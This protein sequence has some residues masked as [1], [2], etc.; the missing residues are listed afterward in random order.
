[1]VAKLS[2]KGVATQ[3]QRIGSAPKADGTAQQKQ[4]GMKQ[5]V[6]C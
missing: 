3:L 2:L 1:M 4:G 5:R 6:V